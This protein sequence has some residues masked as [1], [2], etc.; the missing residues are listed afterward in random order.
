MTE[1]KNRQHQKQLREKEDK[2]NLIKT[3]L[4]FATIL[5]AL[6]ISGTIWSAIANAES[7]QNTHAQLNRTI[8]QRQQTIDR[9][10]MID[11][12][13]RGLTREQWAMRKLIE[14]AISTENM[15]QAIRQWGEEARLSKSQIDAL[16]T[17]TGDDLRTLGRIQNQLSGPA[18]ANGPIGT[19]VF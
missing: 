6:G 4:K 19:I 3:A 11:Q 2:Q 12:S 17:L 7:S 13:S 14:E 9:N 5:T 15:D 8:L 10:I 16:Q 1:A 18:S